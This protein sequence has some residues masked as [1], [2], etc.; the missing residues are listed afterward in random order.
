MQR[1]KTLWFWFTRYMVVIEWEGIR[2]VH[3]SKTEEDA[4]EW[5]RCTPDGIAMY[6]KRGKLIAARWTV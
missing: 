3:W 1:I 6:G 2:K 5:M 4:R